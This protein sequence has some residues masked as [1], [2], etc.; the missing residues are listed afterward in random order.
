MATETH[1]DSKPLPNPAGMLGLKS[2]LHR[3]KLAR[4]AA[5]RDINPRSWRLTMGCGSLLA[6]LIC[7]PI[8]LIWLKTGDI[9]NSWGSFTMRGGWTGFWVTTVIEVAAIVAGSILIL[10]GL[11]TQRSRPNPGH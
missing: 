6:G 9:Q 3:M 10:W 8:N 7:L 1:G 11:F 4:D 5:K 2:R